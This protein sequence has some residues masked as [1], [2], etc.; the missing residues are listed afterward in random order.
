MHTK[1]YHSFALQLQVLIVSI[2]LT[3]TLPI[4]GSTDAIKKAFNSKDYTKAYSLIQSNL[5]DQSKDADILLLAGCQVS[6][7]CGPNAT[8]EPGM[9]QMSSLIIIPRYCVGG[10]S[11]NNYCCDYCIQS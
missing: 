2:V 8:C 5:K 10:R 1:H 9:Y 3:L 11:S 4:Y 6:T 7:D